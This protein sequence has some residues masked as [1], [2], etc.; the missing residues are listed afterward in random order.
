MSRRMHDLPRGS[1]ML[2]ALVLIA[3]SLLTSV[4]GT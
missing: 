2:V 1:P 4:P 3:Q